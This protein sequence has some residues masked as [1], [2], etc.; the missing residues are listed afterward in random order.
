VKDDNVRIAAAVTA[1][2]TN[3]IAIFFFIILYPIRVGHNID[4]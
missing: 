4:L 1:N 2:V 3:V